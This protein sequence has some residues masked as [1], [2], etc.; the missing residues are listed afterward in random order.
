MDVFSMF[1]FHYALKL[2]ESEDQF[3]ERESKYRSWFQLPPFAELFDVTV[4]ARSPRDLGAEMR[5]IRRILDGRMTI[6]A[7]KM[8]GRSPVRGFYAGRIELR[9]S[10]FVIRDASISERKN[11]LVRRL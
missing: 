3:L 7:I 2:L 6:G 11:T 9:G 4:K 5:E 8:V 1:H 10:F